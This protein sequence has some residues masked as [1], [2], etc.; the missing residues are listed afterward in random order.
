MTGK[1]LRRIRKRLALSQAALAERLAV[2]PN[3]VA[4]WERGELSIRDAM[5]RLIELVADAEERGRE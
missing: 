3:T 5:A 4:R 1:A 2:S